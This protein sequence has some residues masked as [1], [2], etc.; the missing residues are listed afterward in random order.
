M[1]K[2][3][4]DVGRRPPLL[5][6]H[7]L[8]AGVEISSTERAA[9]ATPTSKAWRR[10]ALG[11]VVCAVMKRLLISLALTLLA[12]TN[13]CTPRTATTDTSKSSALPPVIGTLP[14]FTLTDQNGQTVTLESLHGHPFVIDFIFTS[15]TEFCLDMTDKMREVRAAL[16][17]GSPVKCVSMSVDPKND[18]P[19]RLKSF[20]ASRGA[21]DP[22]WLFLTGERATVGT[23]MQSLMLAPSGDP[24]KL[25]PQQHSSRLVLVDGEG[26]V[27]GYY[28]Y[29]D[30]EARKRIVLDARALDAGGKP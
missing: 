14:P 9:F 29:D 19:A 24:A 30:A 6:G 25:N 18:T 12:F 21:V 28:P 7:M 4:A 3:F 15:C 5:V 8:R 1:H 2:A 10:G 22:S 27:R 26:K 13:G 16:G 17:S 11:G 20:A 23:I